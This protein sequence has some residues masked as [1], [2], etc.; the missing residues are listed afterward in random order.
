MAPSSKESKLN[1]VLICGDLIIDNHTYKGRRIKA[2]W[3]KVIGTETISTL[4][5]AHLTYSLIKQ[6][7]NGKKVDCWY[8]PELAMNAIKAEHPENHAFAE[9][10]AA[11]DGTRRFK[12]AL[13]Y[14]IVNN[15]S[16]NLDYERIHKSSVDVKDILVIDDGG[17]GFRQSS[18]TSELPK[19]KCCILK[20]NQPLLD[21]YLWKMLM[22]RE[23]ISKLITLISI[24]ELSNFDIKIRKGISWEQTCLDLCYELVHHSLLK[25]LIACKFLVISIGAAGAMVIKNG[26][27]KKLAEFALAYD[28][29]YLESEWEIKENVNGIGQM[30][31]FT[32]GF[33]HDIIN[34]DVR[35]LEKTNIMDLIKCAKSGT[36]YL[37]KMLEVKT[38]WPIPANGTD[39]NADSDSDLTT[40]AEAVFSDAF[41]PSPYWYKQHGQY[42]KDNLWSIFLKNYDRTKGSSG[43]KKDFTK[44]TVLLAALWTAKNG[45]DYLKHVPYYECNKLF[46]IDRN[47]IESLRNI[48]KLISQY[49]EKES[50]KPFSFA[51]FGPP[52]AGKSFTV[53]QIAY[54]LY[55]KKDF[56]KKV[57]FLTFNLSQFRDKTELTGAFHL[58]RDIV[59]QG[60]LPFVFWDEF[61]S[62]NLKWLKY[63]L[64]PMRDGVFQ[65]GKDIHHIGKSIFIFAGST[66]HEM[67]SF[68]P[69]NPA[70]DRATRKKLKIKRRK[71][72]EFKA[73][74]GWEF[75]SR[76]H[77]YLNVPGPN[78]K[79]LYDSTQD[80]WITE[81]PADLMYPV[82]RALYL[83]TCL[84]GKNDKKLKMDP[85]LVMAFLKTGNYK[86]GS[87]SMSRIL[88]HLKID[89]SG[90][91]CRSE[92][93]S[94]E[95]MSLHVDSDEFMK[96]A[97]DNRMDRF[98]LED[99]AK[100]LHLTWLE[101][102]QGNDDQIIFNQ[103]YE[104]LPEG[105]KF[106]L[107]L[108]SKRIL[109]MLKEL[110][111]KVVRNND[112]RPS[113]MVEFK[114]RYIK[115]T[116][117]LEFL[118]KEEHRGWIKAR[119]RAGWSKATIRNDYF[120]KDPRLAKYKNLKSKE[121]EK[122]RNTILNI[123]A[124]FDHLNFKIV[125]AKRTKLNL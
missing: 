104:T 82:R 121:K 62:R 85:G 81:D 116:D 35:N 119:K 63:F 84:G 57:T 9:W 15:V 17:L 32:A 25:Q 105:M 93:P 98:P 94:D 67:Q 3:K 74:K 108:T 92:L 40:Q 16:R 122:D 75:R 4:G 6:F 53:K 41:I 110:G 114:I 72:K 47:E 37:R 124:Y 95:F 36:L 78:R 109:N 60:K 103:E 76:L 49:I 79:L 71:F 39:Q 96:I 83:R 46:T 89:S 29:G 88:K 30:C 73:K 106:D 68:E 115:D 64:A 45:N 70:L 11:R 113:M 91:I 101:T 2:A 28:P 7:K 66:V 69:A 100:A 5:G 65:E 10:E 33:T 120:K 58:V 20:T 22:N 48:R 51:V 42:L 23:R 59:L 86:H 97:N 18:V 61:D 90:Q 80:D 112:P 43:S 1:T 19:Y 87:R 21:G 107:I 44:E 38:G 27:K 99:L 34:R 56:D 102:M 12:R 26:S 54:S 14:G 125:R 31:A 52:R 117:E 111:F 77:A 50:F 8:D 24:H 118:A 13:G 123:P 55:K